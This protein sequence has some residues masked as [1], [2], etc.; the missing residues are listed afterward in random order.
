M[1][2]KS[3]VFNYITLILA[4][5]TILT[6][7]WSIIKNTNPL[8][9]ISSMCAMLVFYFISKK[10]NEKEIMLTKNEKEFLSNIKNKSEEK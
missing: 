9:S 7:I 4:I 1:L 10:I 8:L 3:Q 6:S 5:L 2:N